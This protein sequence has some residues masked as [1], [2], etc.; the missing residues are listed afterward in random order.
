MQ[1]VSRRPSET[2]SARIQPLSVLPVFLDLGGKRAVVAGG[3][4]A[5]AWKVELL[6]AAGAQVEVCSPDDELSEEMSRILTS[7]AAIMHHAR[8]WTPADLVGAR[9]ALADLDEDEARAFDQAARAA[10]AACNVIDKPAFCHFQFGAI[11]NRSPVVIGVS[12]SGAAPILGQAIRR[13]IEALLPPSLAQW[14]AIA[15]DLRE[16]VARVLVGS[17]RRRLFWEMLADRAF[18]CPPGAS[19]E[20]ELRMAIAFGSAV[21]T[22]GHV[23]FVGADP[24]DAEHLTLKAVRALQA[25]DVILFDDLV[26]DEVLEFARRE[27]KRIPVGKCT[28]RPNCRQGEINEMMVALTKAGRRIV[29]LISGDPMI[30]DRISEEIAKL[31]KH[32][33][34]YDVV[35]GIAC[36]GKNHCPDRNGADAQARAG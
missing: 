27:A 24:E 25:A 20:S 12:T 8:Q 35:P 1:V 18:G 11:V 22:A 4:A 34:S 2:G 21:P 17:A 14:A 23:S 31:E 32:N 19:T 3:T 15:R 29:R 9:V 26:S 28:A 5:A 7:R 16:R 33:I 30:F 6:V 10:G 13:R 36:A